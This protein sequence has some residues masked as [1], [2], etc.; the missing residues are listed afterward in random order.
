[1]SRVALIA[2]FGA[3]G[4]L[5]RLGV[6]N[7]VSHRTFP[8]S[9]V[10]INITGS[11][12]LG[13]LV[14]WGS[15]RVSAPVASA[16]GI[17]FLGAYTTFSTFTVDATLLGDEGRVPAAASYLALSVALGVAAAIAGVALGRSLLGQD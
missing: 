16:L 8:W 12:A 17:G 10:L 7:V 13:L 3:A 14:T 11:F 9:T 2:L 4:A 6:N 5:A 15:T 1:M